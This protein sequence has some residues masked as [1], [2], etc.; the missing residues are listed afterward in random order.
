M[1]IGE[2]GQYRDVIGRNTF[3]IK[4]N[5][6][7]PK[8]IFEV[9]IEVKNADRI[10]PLRM[11]ARQ[12]KQYARGKNITPFVASVFL[13]DRAQ[14]ALKEEGVGYLDLAGNF[15]LNQDNFYAE[16]I[17][18][19]NPFSDIPP[20]KNLFAPV[21]SRITRALLIEPNRTWQLN[22]LAKETDV[23]LGQSYSVIEKMIAQ[24]FVFWNTDG[25][26]ALKDPK[27]LLEAWKEVYPT[28]ENKRFSFFSFA[29][30]YDE[31]IVSVLEKGRG[32]VPFAFG[33]FTGAG[34]IA[35]F[36]RGLAKVQLYVENR[37]AVEQMQNLLDLRPVES[38]PNIELFVPYDKGVFYNTQTLTD[39][40]AGEISGCQQYSTLYGFIQ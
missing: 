13:G 24:E 26:I 10:A 12:V 34:F 32:Q 27:L 6:K 2:W 39:S 23:S 30:S 40:R 3:D 4:A 8:G 25:K 14:E 1:P 29:R 15:Y 19:K 5:I 9:I 38:G 11:A 33:S 35:P 21:S 28:Y 16:K 37:E 7:T 22:E 31:I 18:A 36:I 20:L 17:V